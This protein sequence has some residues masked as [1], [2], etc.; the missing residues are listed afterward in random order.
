MLE[1]RIARRFL[2]RSKGQ[3]LL[4]ILGIAIGI[5]VQV[6]VGSLITSLQDSLVDS[7]VGSSSQ[8]TIEPGGDATF[9]EFSAQQRDQ[10]PPTVG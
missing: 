3:S 1:L 5:A 10:W 6:F 4:I 9:F 8:V 2:L 7:T